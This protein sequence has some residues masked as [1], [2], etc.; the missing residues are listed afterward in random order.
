MPDQ[1]TNITTTTTPTVIQKLLSR[2]QQDARPLAFAAV[3]LVFGYLGGQFAASIQ[4]QHGVASQE[5]LPAL[6][7]SPY[8]IIMSP[9]SK[10]STE[11]KPCSMTQTLEGIKL[12]GT[13]AHLPEQQ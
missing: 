1:D 2:I 11:T 10:P 5:Q 12:E 3:G 13:C 9:T 8:G 7:P 4:H 6:V